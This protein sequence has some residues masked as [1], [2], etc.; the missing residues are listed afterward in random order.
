MK[1]RWREGFLII[2]LIILIFATLLIDKDTKIDGSFLCGD[3]TLSKV[4][5]EEWGEGYDFGYASAKE[6]LL[7]ISCEDCAEVCYGD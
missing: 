7:Q 4:R 3:K 2:F 1:L 6:E 5:F